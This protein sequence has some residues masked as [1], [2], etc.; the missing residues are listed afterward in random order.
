MAAVA[1]AGGGAPELGPTRPTPGL[2]PRDLLPLLMPE[3][4][5]E[6]KAH[7]GEVSGGAAGA[8]LH[9]TV[10][11]DPNGPGGATLSLGSG[12]PVGVAAGPWAPE[13]AAAPSSPSAVPAP[14]T[15]APISGLVGAAGRK[16]R[17][18]TCHQHTRTRRGRSTRAEGCSARSAVKIKA[19]YLVFCAGRG[20]CG[21]A[22]TP[23]ASAEQPE[24][25]QD[26][27]AGPQRVTG[28][29]SGR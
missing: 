18:L 7:P 12:A 25:P 8:C 24:S 4:P 21:L 9:L 22:H 15:S 11:K 5:R 3:A 26:T 27:Q 16:S 1:P 6:P 29:P 13:A 19:F 23:V 20:T 17:P 2:G 10:S 14:P 28:S